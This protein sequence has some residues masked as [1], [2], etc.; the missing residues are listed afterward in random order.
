MDP[1]SERL[2]S[3]T[4]V[5]LKSPA[6]AGKLADHFSSHDLRHARQ[7]TAQEA[8]LFHQPE[9]AREAFKLRFALSFKDWF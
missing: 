2:N 1:R 9:K 6:I 4:A 8:L 3:E 5:A 7:I